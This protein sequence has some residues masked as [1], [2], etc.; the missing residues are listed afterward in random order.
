M[1]A[2]DFRSAEPQLTP[3]GYIRTESGGHRLSDKAYN[4]RWVARVR[5]KTVVD[6]NGCWNWQ[7]WLQTKG[8]GGTGYR[9]AT[10]AIHR[11]IYKLLVRADLKTE[12]F[13]CHTCD[14][15]KC[16][17]PQHLWVGTNGDNQRD[18]GMK[19]R[20]QESKKTHCPKGHE[21]TPENTYI[22]WQSGRRGLGRAC[23]ACQK[24]RMNSPAY[25]ARALERQRLK[26][27]KKRLAVAEGVTGVL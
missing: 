3:K 23:V 12:E 5:A 18:A 7:G 25:K 9:G 26:R 2:S 27:R 13:V 11:Q 14:N 4:A 6:A 10:V 19:G 24:I 17:N 8:Y 20:H 16:W 15:R 21:Y 22:R 1:T